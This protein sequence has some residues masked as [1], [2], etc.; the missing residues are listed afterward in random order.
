MTRLVRTM[1]LALASSILTTG[2]HAAPLCPEFTSPDLMPSKYRKLA[3]V[4]SGGSTDWIITADQ[5]D[6]NYV[7]ASQAQFLLREI[8]R[9]FEA[10][11][12]KLAILMAPPRPLVAGQ[13]AIDALGN[14]P[15]EFDIAAVTDNYNEMVTMVEAAGII[16]PNLLA[17]ATGSSEI[18]Q[19][20]YYR[21]DTHWTPAGAAYSAVALAEAV[22]AANLPSFSGMTL[23][24]PD[25]SGTSE[26]YTENGS[27]ALMANKVCGADI[28]PVVS[29]FPAFDN[30]HADLLGDTL[31]NK[32]KVILAGSSFS[33]RYKRDAYRVANAVASTMGANVLNASVAGGGAIGGIEGALLTGL[34]DKDNPPA[35]VVWE[36]PYTE[37]LRSPSTLRQLLDA[38]ALS[39][40]KKMAAGRTLDTSGK[41]VI[42]LANT[43]AELI[44]FKLPDTEIE[45]IKVKISFE[46]RKDMNLKLRR[47]TRVP[48]ELRSDY[49]SLSLAGMA[50]DKPVSAT[51]TY[52]GARIGAGAVFGF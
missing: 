4:L 20:F 43:N 50:K 6:V 40:G 3:P 15:E 30:Q 28:S 26:T 27:L 1:A 5:M 38:L 2:V 31:G 7:P 33:N 14:N 23:T 36:V 45:E 39:N 48:A 11:G 18:R 16:M 47:K 24:L 32:P 29:G 44:T 42:S 9:Q 17:V 37:G 21:H 8:A 46:K 10:K 13:E 52:D 12:T 51:F 22:A 19:D 49:W 35:L 34:V 41:T 25:F